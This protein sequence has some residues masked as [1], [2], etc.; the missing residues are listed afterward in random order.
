MYGSSPTVLARLGL[1]TLSSSEDHSTEGP[2]QL[3]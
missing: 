1:H 3:R 2:L